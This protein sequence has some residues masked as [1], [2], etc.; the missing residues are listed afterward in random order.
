ML[1]SHIIE[2]EYKL[3]VQKFQYNIPYFKGTIT[4]SKI[5]YGGQVVLKEIKTTAKDDERLWDAFI[6]AARVEEF[7]LGVGLGKK[8]ENYY[9]YLKTLKGISGID[10]EEIARR[11]KKNVMYGQ[12]H[13]NDDLLKKRHYSIELNG[14]AG[15]HI[16]HN[17]KYIPKGKTG[18][19]KE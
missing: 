7:S 18:K 1:I 11:D 4:L 6:K 2:K 5:G 15:I 3:R 17:L 16:T 14:D 10:A 8:D 19:S 13:C 9:K 12:S